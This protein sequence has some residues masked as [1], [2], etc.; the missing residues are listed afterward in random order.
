MLAVFTCPNTSVTFHEG[1]PQGCPAAL[2]SRRMR[3]CAEKIQRL[4]WAAGAAISS[5]SH[6]R[7]QGA[8]MAQVDLKK[9]DS[10]IKTGAR[11]SSIVEPFP[12][13][14]SQASQVYIISLGTQ[15]QLKKADYAPSV[16]QLKRSCATQQAYRQ[17][18]TLLT[19]QPSR[20]CLVLRSL[21][22]LCWGSH[23]W[24]LNG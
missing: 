6:P 16:K 14:I 17:H 13:P 23:L 5:Y 15:K 1:Y 3:V 12:A 9:N 11:F 20:Q 21:Q 8:S 2:R 22:S 24:G 19:F 18:T 7:L 10:P 4:R